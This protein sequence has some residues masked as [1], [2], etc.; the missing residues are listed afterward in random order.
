M[1]SATTMIKIRIFVG[2]PYRDSVL[3][4]F[5]PPPPNKTPL[6]QLHVTCEIRSRVCITNLEST[7]YQVDQSA[8][9][10]SEICTQICF[11]LTVGATTAT[12]TSY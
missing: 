4:L 9:T 10:N 7:P 2:L 8:Q 5:P 12:R 6:L 1:K 11:K 3:Y